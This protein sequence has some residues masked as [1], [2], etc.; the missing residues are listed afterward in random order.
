MPWSPPIPPISGSV[1]TVAWAQANVVDTITWL[2]QLTGGVDPGASN[3]VLVSNGPTST[4]WGQVPDVALAV[5]KVSRTGDTMT[6]D[7][8]VN[9]GS[10]PTGY[11]ILGNNTAYFFGFDGSQ[12]VLQTP[13]LTVGGDVYVNRAA[14]PTQGYVILGN[15]AAHYVGFNGIEILA[16]GSPVWTDANA[17]LRV[18]TPRLADLAVTT[19]KLADGAVTVAKLH[20]SVPTVPSGLIAAFLTAAAIP[21]GWTRFTAANGKQLIGA[22]TAGGQTF[23]ENTPAGGAWTHGHTAGISGS[24]STTVNVAIPGTQS[25]AGSDHG[26]TITNSTDTWI[27]PSYTVVWAMK[28]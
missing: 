8:Q 23:L 2:R 13:Q 3:K 27:P 18:T 12:H 5:P 7:L 11:L 10:G 1:I 22:G 16:D 24:P 21:T 9:R 17:P 14:T 15:S 6:G 26:H 4:A 20:S 19:P 25:V 28:S